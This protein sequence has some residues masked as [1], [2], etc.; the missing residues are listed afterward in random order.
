MHRSEVL[1]NLTAAMRVLCNL[2]ARGEL[3]EVLAASP[4][5]GRPIT[6]ANRRLSP[7]EIDQIVEDYK[8]GVGSIYDLA[9]IYGVHRN[10]VAQHLKARGVQL[11][12]QAL[13][14]EEIERAK[15]LARQGLSGNAIGRAMM[16]DPKTVRRALQ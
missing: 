16:R 2:V 4:R 10:T 5:P 1:A 7:A 8:T 9:D 15:E 11:G 6:G 13:S 3:S 14:P 12:G